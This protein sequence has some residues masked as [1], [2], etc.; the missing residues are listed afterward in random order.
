Y[1]LVFVTK[2][3]K[4]M[5][6]MKDAMWAADKTGS[7]RFSDRTDPAQRTLLLDEPAWVGP[8][9]K[10][11]HAKFAGREVPIEEVR[12]FL[13][14]ETPFRFRKG[15]LKRLEE[16]GKIIDVSLRQKAGTFPDGCSIQ[17]A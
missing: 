3:I 1:Y 12:T 16:E 11:V 8:A 6:V 4:G 14:L 17:F 10:A 7:Y 2:S 13:L 5:E 15:I 9:A